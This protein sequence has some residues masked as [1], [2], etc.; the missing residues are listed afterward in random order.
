MLCLQEVNGQE[1]DGGRSL[2]AL[3][4]LL[5]GT[6][7]E[8]FHR[9]STRVSDGSK[10]YAER[11]LVILSRFEIMESD[12][13]RNDY[14][15]APL[16]REVTASGAEDAQA[17]EVAWERPIQHARLDLG[18]AADGRELDVLNL[19]LKSRIPTPVQGQKRDA[20]TW[21]SAAGWAEGFF[22]SSMKRVG[23][24]LEARMLIDSIFDRD[25]G[26]MIAV[27]GDFNADLDEVPVKAIRGDVEETGNAD[28]SS[29]VMIPAERTIPESTRYTLLYRG[30]ERML[31]HVLASRSLLS[32]YQGS[33][34]H[35]E[36]LHDESIA[37]AT[38]EKFPES[39]HAPVIAEFE[40]PDK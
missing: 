38:D 39:D 21:R 1:T 16:Y 37:F 10:V 12:Q 4:E 8:G 3:E 20:Y 6:G 29:R 32:H 34:V 35:N 26:A 33:E 7:Y 36:I 40:L 13:Y 9:V 24:A 18:G 25:E 28:L 11:N 17:D 30:Q 22:I 2:S 27:V 14:A 15:P 19:H 31:D 23:Q 5:E